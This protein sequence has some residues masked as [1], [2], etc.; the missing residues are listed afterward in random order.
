MKLYDMVLFCIAGHG[1]GWAFSSVDL[2]NKFDRQQIDNVLS[3]LSK[4]KKI[5]RVARG[6]YDYPKYSELL[7]KELSPDIEQVAL[8]IA[9]KF[10]WR[11][12]VSGN[13]ALNILNLSTQI[14]AKYIYLSD[15]PN[16][17][18]KLLNDVVIEFKKSTLKDIGFKYKESSLIVQA[19][20]ELGKENI[21]NE[22]IEKIKDKIEPKMYEKILKDTQTTTVWIYEIIKK[23]CKDNNNV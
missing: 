21:T 22:T 8:A 14:Q 15:G 11:I 17:S 2:I 23:I 5:R 13:S 20:K 18:Y 16:R 19:L 9:R 1:R 3:D 4:D 10:N 7:K 6:I 12:E